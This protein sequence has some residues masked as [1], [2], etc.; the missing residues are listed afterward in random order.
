MTIFSQ[1]IEIMLLIRRPQDLDF[2]QTAAILYLVLTIGINYISTSFSG[3]FSQPLLISAVQNLAIVALLFGLL[4]VSGKSQRF[5]QTCTALF[6]INAVI[7]I[8]TLL[9]VQVPLIGMLAVVLMGW[10]FYLMVLVLR[11]AFDATILKAILLLILINVV[12]GFFTTAVVPSYFEEFKTL[13]QA[14][15]A[16]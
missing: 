3:A 8:L 13:M 10:S 2:D 9:I 1:L 4:S 6:G 14:N 7:S 12:A 16:V 5:V 11:D 15:Q